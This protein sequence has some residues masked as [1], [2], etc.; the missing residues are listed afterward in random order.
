MISPSSTEKMSIHLSSPGFSIA[1]SDTLSPQRGTI[2]MDCPT[3]RERCAHFLCSKQLIQLLSAPPYV[4]GM[5]GGTST[6]AAFVG[7]HK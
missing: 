6:M 7:I 5:F 4:D 3:I 2:S 1:L